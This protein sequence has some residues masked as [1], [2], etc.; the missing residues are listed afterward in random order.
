M[1]YCFYVS[2]LNRRKH[3]WVYSAYTVLY[4]TQYLVLG[5][6]KSFDY[7]YNEL[8]YQDSKN[9]FSI[10]GFIHI[11]ILL[12]QDNFYRVQNIF[13][14][15]LVINIF[16]LFCKVEL[17][18]V[19]RGSMDAGM[20]VRG[21]NSEFLPMKVVVVTSLLRRRALLICFVG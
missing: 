2:F 19:T 8:P 16:S 1:I 10:A 3:G 4:S 7:I 9:N 21:E 17:S 20:L 15:S 6:V 18:I 13:G 14:H 5:S 12:P 11:S